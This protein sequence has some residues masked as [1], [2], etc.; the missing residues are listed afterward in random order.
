M[1]SGIMRHKSW[2]E[3]PANALPFCIGFFF[4]FPLIFGSMAAFFHSWSE[5]TLLPDFIQE[6][7]TIIATSQEF[8]RLLAVHFWLK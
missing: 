5:S 8:N 1:K 7:Q 6:E 3:F 2:L 4:L